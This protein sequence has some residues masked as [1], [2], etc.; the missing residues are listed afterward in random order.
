MKVYDA[1]ANAFVKEGAT[2]LFG[3]LGDGQMTWWASMAKRGTRIIDVRDEG[4]ALAMAEGWSRASG[5]IGVC[6]VTQG[7]GLT[8][9][10]TSLCA[11][12][13]SNTPI[14][15]QTSKIA[16]NSEKHSQFLD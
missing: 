14:V 11:A 7:P 16:A 9:T 2:T 12:V 4:A 8:R 6:S 1:V 13:R 5:R 3:L 10:I 15:V